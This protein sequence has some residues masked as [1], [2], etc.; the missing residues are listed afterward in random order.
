MNTYTII[1]TINNQHQLE[2]HRQTVRYHGELISLYDK[3]KTQIAQSEYHS[4]VTD[5]GEHVYRREEILSFKIEDAP[6]SK[7][8]FILY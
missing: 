1:Y 4:F 2:E 6:P 7:T 8:A 3:I 5:H